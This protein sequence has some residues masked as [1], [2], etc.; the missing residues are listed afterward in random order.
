MRYDESEGCAVFLG[1]LS[2]AYSGGFASTRSQPWQWDLQGAKVR[3]QPA[4][5]FRFF[6]QPLPPLLPLCFPPNSCSCFL[7]PPLLLPFH[8]S[9]P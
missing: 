6:P 9:P 2:T 8:N 4:C 3:Q 7:L 5:S 1:E